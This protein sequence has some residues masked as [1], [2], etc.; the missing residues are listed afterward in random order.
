[1]NSFWIK[2][3]GFSCQTKINFTEQG[4]LTTSE[5][6]HFEIII[7]SWK[8]LTSTANSLD[9]PC[10]NYDFQRTEEGCSNVNSL[11]V[12]VDGGWPFFDFTSNQ[13]CNHDSSET[14]LETLSI[15]EK[16]L[17]TLLNTNINEAEVSS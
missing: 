13:K 1:M 17:Q 10:L 12:F 7:D 3:D 16:A 2:L 9:V 4:P 6:E 11:V 14:I 8:L 5:M 15:P